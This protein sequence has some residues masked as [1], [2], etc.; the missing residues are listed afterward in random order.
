MI[1]CLRYATIVFPFTTVQIYLTKR[2][3]TEPFYEQH[4][5]AAVMF[6]TIIHRRTD[7]MDLR[8]M[9]EII[10][11]FDEILSFYKYPVKVEKIKVINWTYMAACG[12]SAK[13]DYWHDSLQSVKSK[14]RNFDNPPIQLRIGINL[15]LFKFNNYGLPI[16]H[17]QLGIS[18]GE[19]MAGVVGSFQAHYDVWGN[20]VNMASRMDTT[21]EPGRIQVTEETAEVLRSFDIGCTYRGLT[22]VK[23][24]GNIPTYFINVDEEFKFQEQ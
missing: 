8:L 4:D 11:D 22:E 13:R 2:L 6:A 19:V 12:L 10:C 21:G 14:A 7:S 24:R 23:G 3:Q 5:Y 18:S 9:N 16:M 20:A 17:F 15:L 1:L